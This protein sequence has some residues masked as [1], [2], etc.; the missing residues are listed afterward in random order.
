M[1][2][3]G[4]GCCCQLLPIQRVH[5]YQRYLTDEQ[6]QSLT[7]ALEAK[8]YTVETNVL[9]FPEQ[10]RSSSVVYSLVINMDRAVN[11]LL[12]ILTE[13]GWLSVQVQPLF[14]G[15]HWFSKNSIGLFLVPDDTDV[16]APSYLDF[17]D[18]YVAEQCDEKATLHLSVD[19]SYR[20]SYQNSKQ[21]NPVVING[22][23][24]MQHYPYITLTPTDSNRSFHY[25]GK[26]K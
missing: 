1:Y 24:V 7:T 4:V 21:D 8:N 5:L 15:N 11:D 17:A 23:W 6:V 9:P 19:K 25:E 12:P 2:S 3:L 18:N 14:S 20:M 16:S 22:A 13:Q 10:M 26:S